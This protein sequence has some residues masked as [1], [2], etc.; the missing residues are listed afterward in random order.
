MGYLFFV[1]RYDPSYDNC[2]L[3]SNCT[4]NLVNNFLTNVFTC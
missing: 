1:I 2:P 3:T 4:L